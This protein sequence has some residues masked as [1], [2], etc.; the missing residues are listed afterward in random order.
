[1]VGQ[2]DLDKMTDTPAKMTRNQKQ[3]RQMILDAALDVFSLDGFRG[4]SL[5]QIALKAG[6][7]K[8]NLLYY[9]S[10]KEEIHT[11][12][13]EGLLDAWLSPL[14]AMD[15]QGDPLTE[16]LKYLDAKMNMAMSYP[17]ESRL[18]ANEILRGAPHLENYLKGSLKSLVEEKSI[19]LQKWM[20]LGQLRQVDPKHLFFSIWAMTQH[21]ADFDVQVSAILGEDRESNFA[22]A[23][24]F[25]ATMISQLLAP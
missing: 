6:I 4:T 24:V 8:P 16:V 5:D 19:L 23:R 25:Q 9:F 22:Q 14:R 12:L 21:Y 17:L 20:D 13:L 15:A 10:G 3:K 18:F 7:S 1:M 2:I 11:A